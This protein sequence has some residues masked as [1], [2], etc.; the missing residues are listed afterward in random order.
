MRRS[1]LREMGLSSTAVTHLS[2][3]YPGHVGAVTVRIEVVGERNILDHLALVRVELAFRYGRSAQKKE[4]PYNGWFE[5]R[6]HSREKQGTA[7]QQYKNTVE[8]ALRRHIFRRGTNDPASDM[9]VFLR[10]G[11]RKVQN[12]W[13]E[14]Y[15]K[16]TKTDG[17]AKV[18]PATTLSQLSSMGKDAEGRPSAITA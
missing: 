1:V 12:A 17:G 3:C 7:V 14:K 4:Y 9:V 18:K 6:T 8:G 16:A 15:R 13:V 2:G 10:L 11:Q 5:Y